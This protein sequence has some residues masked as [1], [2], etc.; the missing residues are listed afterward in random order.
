MRLTLSAVNWVLVLMVAYSLVSLIVLFRID[1]I[2]NE[3]L[4]LY[5]L[6]FSP[7]WAT[8][9][10]N[11][12]RTVFAMSWLSIITGLVFFVYLTARKNGEKTE[13]KREMEPRNEDLWHR[14]TLSDGSAIKV[15]YVL[16]GAKRLEKHS[17]DGMS[18]YVVESDNIV[19]V[20]SVPTKL[21]EKP[22]RKRRSNKASLANL[23]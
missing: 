22:R 2:V 7:E 8:Q 23:A 10:W 4:Y 17:S 21:I 12:I 18:I 20:V 6:Q 16:K 1:T 5:G 19:Q 11:S 13:E 15:K 3:N 14:Y 9:Y